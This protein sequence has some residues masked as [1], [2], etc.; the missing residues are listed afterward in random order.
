MYQMG[1]G[2]TRPSV[3]IALRLA[4]QGDDAKNGTGSKKK[5]VVICN[6]AVRKNYIS[7]IDSYIRNYGNKLREHR[8]IQPG[9]KSAHPDALYHK[10]QQDNR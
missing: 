10:W 2:K 3:A 8:G 9:T 6:G 7:E 5:I 1:A 4:Y